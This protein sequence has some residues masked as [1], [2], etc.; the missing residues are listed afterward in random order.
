MSSLKKAAAIAV[1]ALAPATHLHAQAAENG[2][3]FPDFSAT[4]VFRTPAYDIN[5]KISRS[6]SRIRVDKDDAISILYVSLD[7]VY[8]LTGYPDGS[9]QCVVMKPDQPHGLP[10]PLELLNGTKVKRSPAGTEVVEGHKCNV[11][12]AVV[13]RADGST[14][15]AKVWEAQDL[16]GIPVKIESQLGGHKFTALYRD[17]K[18]GTPDQALVTPPAKCTPFEKMW[19]VVEQK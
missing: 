4:E 3:N 19:Q 12:T 16:K 10:S 2:W 11:E 7:K 9:H 8:S 6:G 1:L 17:I 18:I 15:E 13:T 5:L 14:V